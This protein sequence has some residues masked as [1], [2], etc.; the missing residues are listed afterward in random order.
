MNAVL[1]E[2][3]QHASR[4]GSLT[5]PSL[6]GD[7]DLRSRP[8]PQVLRDSPRPP[9][10]TGAQVKNK[11]A[12]EQGGIVLS[13]NRGAAMTHKIRT[14]L[15]PT[16]AEP[17]ERLPLGRRLPPPGSWGRT[18]RIQS[19]ADAGRWPSESPKWVNSGPNAAR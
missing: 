19:P 1:E 10:G 2:D 7:R 17:G 16:L 11:V 3:V 13:G 15:D 6:T 4:E 18:L 5:S 8:A 14:G 9:L 12:E